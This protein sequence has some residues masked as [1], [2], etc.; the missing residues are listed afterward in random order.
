MQRQDGRRHLRTK[1]VRLPKRD[2]REQIER[3]R[4]QFR[5]ARQQRRGAVEEAE[6]RGERDRFGGLEHDPSRVARVTFS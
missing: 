5:D 3:D 1:D 4:W 6:S 2:A